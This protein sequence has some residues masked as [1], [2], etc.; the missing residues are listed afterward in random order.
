MNGREKLTGSIGGM[1]NKIGKIMIIRIYTWLNTVILMRDKCYK[2]LKQ[3]CKGNKQSFPKQ[4]YAKQSLNIIYISLHTYY[5][6]NQHEKSSHRGVERVFVLIIIIL[7]ILLHIPPMEPVILL[8]YPLHL[9]VFLY[10]LII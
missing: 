5:L 8:S 9:Y 10:Q 7:P 4:M 6:K 3:Q 2:G 1:Y